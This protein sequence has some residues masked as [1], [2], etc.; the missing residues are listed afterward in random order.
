MC[1]VSLCELERLT[2]MF[3]DTVSIISCA[4]LSIELEKNSIQDNEFRT[5]RI[6]TCIEKKIHILYMI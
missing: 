1:N 2:G 4:R 3:R 6:Y 5:N